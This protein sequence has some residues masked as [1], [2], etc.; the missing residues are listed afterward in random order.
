MHKLVKLAVIAAMAAGASTLSAAPLQNGSFAGGTLAGWTQ[1]GNASVE[2]SLAGPAPS[3]NPFQAFVGNVGV[4]LYALG[5]GAAVPGA[6]LI[7]SIGV[8]PGDLALLKDPADS[9]G[10]DY[11]SAITQTFNANAGEQIRFDWNFLTDEFEN[12]NGNDFAFVVLDGKLERLSNTF[13]P[14]GLTS[15]VFS[16]ETGFQAF[17]MNVLTSGL[18][19]I[20]FGVVDVNGALGASAVLIDNVRAVPEA[21]SVLMVVAGLSFMVFIARRRTTSTRDWGLGALNCRD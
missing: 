15:S 14:L 5:S 9:G 2:N 11:G 10:V 21:D 6:T 19:T 18:H 1:T 3:G 20:G 13:N 4:A 12:H 17:S 16:N 8:T 7:G